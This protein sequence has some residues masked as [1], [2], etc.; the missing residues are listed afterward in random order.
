MLLF[1]LLIVYINRKINKNIIK[2]DLVDFKKEYT[3]K[4]K[5]DEMHS[6]DY[7]S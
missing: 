5:I 6:L 3:Q 2:K 4:K 1:L 7:Y